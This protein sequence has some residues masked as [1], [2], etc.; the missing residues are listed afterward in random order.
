MGH[1][2]QAAARG[3]NGVNPLN[4]LKA[5]ARSN[6]W[7]EARGGFATIFRSL[8]PAGFS[9]RC[10]GKKVSAQFTFFAKC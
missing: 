4:R 7:R 6:P 3:G 2:I 1:D 8:I 10:G 9:R 5:R